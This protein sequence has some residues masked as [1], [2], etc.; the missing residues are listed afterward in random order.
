[1]K[2]FLLLSAG[3]AFGMTVIAQTTTKF[4]CVADTWIRENQEYSGSTTPTLETNLYTDSEGVTS[5][6]SIL[7]GFSFNVP[8]GQ[9]IENA[10]L[11]F[12]TSRYK[13]GTVDL[14]G[15]SHDFAETANWFD[16]QSYIN[17]TLGGNYLYQFNPAGQ[18]NKDLGLDKCDP[19]N[20]D[21]AKW[22]NEFDVTAYVKSLPANATRANFLITNGTL[23]NC[24][25]SKDNQGTD[26]FKQEDDSFKTHFDASE[27][28]P[29][30]LVTFVEDDGV[31]ITK[32]PAI[33]DVWVRESSPN[34]KYNNAGTVEIGTSDNK[35]EDGELVQANRRAALYGFNFSVPAGKEIQSAK[36]HLVSERNKTT[37]TTTEV[38]AYESFVESDATWNSELSKIEAALAKEPIVTFTSAGDGTK[39]IF[40]GNISEEKQS[41]EA[42]TNEMD[43][44]EYV[45]GLNGSAYFLLY[46]TGN[47]SRYYTKDNNG[48]E[49]AFK[50]TP[51]A[52]TLTSDQLMPYLII[53]FVGSENDDPAAVEVVIDLNAPVEYYNLNGVRV[54]NPDK[55]IYIVR[56]GN[57]VKKVVL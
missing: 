12:I 32:F 57:V 34:D 22:T 28:M 24:F 14:Y 15:Y 40:D 29:Y 19:D 52:T 46:A 25:Y 50:E 45:K 4:N 20:E 44:T 7:Y 53:A 23:Q 16:E 55:G 42:W 6:F 10:T 2:K 27:L 37:D 51:N 3:L 33:A 11:H 21:L 38:Y 48:Q 13:G 35:Y 5:Q 26:A 43:V 1:M 47:E 9:K 30:L 56:Q 49:N 36:L 39:A 17:E 8:A 41:V 54:V 18:W 31:D